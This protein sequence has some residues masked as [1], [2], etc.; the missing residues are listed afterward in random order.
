MLYGRSMCF[1]SFKL[2]KTALE[3]PSPNLRAFLACELCQRWR[4]VFSFTAGDLGQIFLEE[5]TPKRRF[6]FDGLLMSQKFRIGERLKSRP[7]FST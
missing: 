1:H 5:V 4:K 2:L 6:E 3:P 7:C